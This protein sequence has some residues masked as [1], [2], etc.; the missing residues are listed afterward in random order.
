MDKYVFFSGLWQQAGQILGK[1]ALLYCAWD[2]PCLKCWKSQVR[3]FAA[4]G[5][6]TVPLKLVRRSN[7]IAS[8]DTR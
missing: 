8:V 3:W 7:Q 4:T 5:T 1:A 6:T 2:P